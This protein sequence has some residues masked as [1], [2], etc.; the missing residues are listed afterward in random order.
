[1]EFISPSFIAEKLLPLV[2]FLSLCLPC[3]ELDSVLP[4][5]GVSVQLFMAGDSFSVPMSLQGH[6][7]KFRYVEVVSRSYGCFWLVASSQGHL[8]ELEQVGMVSLQKGD[9]SALGHL[10]E[11]EMVGHSV[12]AMNASGW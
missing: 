10:G 2:Y 4:E 9:N 1:M 6:L 11:L 8:R 7:R 3:R 5:L 12:S